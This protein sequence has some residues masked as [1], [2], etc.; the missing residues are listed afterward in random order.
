[1]SDQRKDS[2]S[3]SEDREVRHPLVENLKED[4]I[5]EVTPCEFSKS[6]VNKSSLGY[7]AHICS[8]ELDADQR[9]IKDQEAMRHQTPTATAVASKMKKMDLKENNEFDNGSVKS[10]LERRAKKALPSMEARQAMEI[11]KRRQRAR[12]QR[13]RQEQVNL[14]YQEE[15]MAK[16]E[17]GEVQYGPYTPLFSQETNF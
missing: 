7:R 6:S 3:V 5:F 8:C 2:K 15:M 16:F 14:C 13:R 9:T 17:T 11:Y 10:A 1:M 4:D 12:I